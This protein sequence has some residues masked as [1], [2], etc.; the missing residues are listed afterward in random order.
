M[1]TKLSCLYEHLVSR[2]P[3]VRL[4]QQLSQTQP[5][6][7]TLSGH[8]LSGAKMA[9]MQ[10]P[11]QQRSLNEVLTELR[12]RNFVDKCQLNIQVGATHDGAF[13]LHTTVGGWW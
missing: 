9:N 6:T 12:C 5:L 1:Y 7:M 11:N 8:L 13:I 4:G 3:L 2:Y 10:L